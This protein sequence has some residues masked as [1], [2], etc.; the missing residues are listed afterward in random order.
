M[1]AR[2]LIGAAELGLIALTQACLACDDE[3][4]R[5]STYQARGKKCPVVSDIKEVPF[6]DEPGTDAAYDRFRFTSDCDQVLIKTLK[7]LKPMT[8]PVC[9]SYGGYVE[10]DAVFWLLLKKHSLDILDVLPKSEH[11][12][13]KEQGVYAYYAYVEEPQRRAKLNARLLTLVDNAKK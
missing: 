12:N 3:N 7:S 1:R 2:T 13:W 10:A 6:H 11:A 9:P 4:G 8:S 5:A